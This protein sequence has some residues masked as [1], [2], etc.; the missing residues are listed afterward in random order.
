MG[1][2]NEQLN[3]RDSF[4]GAVSYLS[5]EHYSDALSTGDVLQQS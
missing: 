4:Y 1:R 2:A 5:K 3:C